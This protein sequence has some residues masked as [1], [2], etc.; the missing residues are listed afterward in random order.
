MRKAESVWYLSYLKEHG[1][2][3]HIEEKGRLEMGIW[4]M[5]K[6]VCVREGYNAFERGFGNREK[7]AMYFHEFMKR[8]CSPS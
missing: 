2:W 4:K 3:S 5:I 7:E 8:G 1:G 6:R